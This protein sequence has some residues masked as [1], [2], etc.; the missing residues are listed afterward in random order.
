MLS[1]I[2]REEIQWL[3]AGYAAK[4]KIT[5]LSGEPGC[6]KS[7]ISIDWAARYSTGRGWP[8]KPLQAPGKVLIFATEDN[9][10]D[11]ILPRFLAAGGNPTKL[12]R[13]RL[14]GDYGFYF[15]DPK[16]L[17]ILRAVTEQPPELGWSSLTRSWN[18]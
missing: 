5:G 9:A 1:N 15:D 3:F 18:T 11:T 17:D 10:S 4:G 7:V 8:D 14:E 6:G 16:H 2:V 13:I 12:Y